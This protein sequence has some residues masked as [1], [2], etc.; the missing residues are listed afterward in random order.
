[1]TPTKCYVLRVSLQTRVLSNIRG[2]ARFGLL[3]N[4]ACI[5][6]S[7][8]LEKRVFA[9]LVR[10]ADGKIT[11]RR[12][13]RIG[14]HV[15]WPRL[16]AG[17]VAMILR[18]GCGHVRMCHLRGRVRV[19]RVMSGGYILDRWKR[20][21]QFVIPHHLLCP[22]VPGHL[23]DRLFRAVTFDRSL[24]F[25]LVSGNGDVSRHLV[26][27]ESRNAEYYSFKPATFIL[28]IH[29]SP[30]QSRKIFLFALS[31]S[32]LVRLFS[33]LKCFIERPLTK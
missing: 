5:S 25:F 8:I 24:D 16:D 11:S 29:F 3:A 9:R 2:N 4:L 27:R 17:H 19:M 6:R 26:N 32:I 21:L 14:L 15:I 10:A 30:W 31:T 18:V 12:L 1:M 13:L 28:N 20:R 23:R 33:H 22:V 7:R